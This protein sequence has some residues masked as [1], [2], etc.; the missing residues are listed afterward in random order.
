[1][2]TP[3]SRFAYH[4]FNF[5][6]QSSQKLDTVLRCLIGQLC[7]FDEYLPI[8]ALGLYEE[9]DNG[10]KQPGDDVLANVLFN[11]LIQDPAKR[12]FL[13]VDALDEC[14]VESRE[15][16]FEL[17][18]DR[19]EQHHTTASTC[20]NFLITSRKERDIEERVTGL[21]GKLHN[22]PLLTDSVNEDIRLHVREFIS[23]HRVMKGWSGHL[24]AEILDTIAG[25]A[26]GM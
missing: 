26:Y 20:Y 19:I 25:G 12:S 8:A 9:C 10:R 22:F 4:Y 24:K 2:T 21:S 13:I 11:I 23:K 3:G 5:G 6:D 14:P 7:K 18:L 17:V 15:R 16:F 1:M